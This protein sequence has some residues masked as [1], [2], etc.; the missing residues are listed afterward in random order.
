MTLRTGRFFEGLPDFSGRSS[1][2]IRQSLRSKGPVFR[3][4]GNAIQRLR[5][6]RVKASYVRE[7]FGWFPQ[8]YPFKKIVIL[9]LAEDEM[10]DLDENL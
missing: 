3:S 4:F 8:A 10:K 7:A 5:N 2:K 1:G 9:P 6:E